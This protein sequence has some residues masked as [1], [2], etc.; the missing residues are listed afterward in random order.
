MI[1]AERRAVAVKTEFGIRSAVSVFGTSVGDPEQMETLG[2]ASPL[3]DALVC[4]LAENGITLLNG[5]YL[6]TMSGLARRVLEKGG[7]A[8]GFAA[9][10]ISDPLERQYFTDIIVLDDHWERLSLLVE[11]A[12][13]FIVL[14]GGVGTL[15]EIATALWAMDRRLCR[16]KPLM[17]LGDYWRPVVSAFSSLP[18]MFRSQAPSEVLFV[19]EP[20]TLRRILAGL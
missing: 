14:P 5:G 15:T 18:M 11:A 13:A 17:L 10:T 3:I 4:A 2:V 6:G 7:T 9:S 1:A 12:D 16:P 20:G 8:L 19:E